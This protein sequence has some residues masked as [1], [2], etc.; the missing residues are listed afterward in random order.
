MEEPLRDVSDTALWVAMYRALESE[1]PDAIFRDRFARQMAGARGEAILASI[2]KARSLAWP[3]V[4]RTAVMDEIIMR[5]VGQGVR[6]IVN[7]AAGLDTR[8][9]RLDLPPDLAWFDADLPAMVAYRAEHMAGV[10]ARC[11]HEEVAVDLRH[12]AGRAELLARL[13][14]DGR[15]GLAITEGLLV[16]LT[17]DDVAALAGELS[18]AASLAWWLIDL[19][20]PLLLKMLARSW[21]PTLQ[22]ANAPMQFAPA[23]STAFFEPYGWWE[24]EFR[25]TW[26]ESRR[27]KR[28][29]RFAGLWEFLG[30][31]RSAETR[32]E[33][34]RMSG[35]VLLERK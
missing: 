35:V 6:T 9:Y 22:A 21:Q 29:V 25:S 10:A 5:L 12:A 33:F 19:A 13:P 4:V 3:M 34:G 14:A 23:E 31:F 1:R 8:A 32:R 2:P 20:S 26:A 18:G 15:P 30:R 11:R 28:T 16:Y 24:V 27:L 17:R 7:L